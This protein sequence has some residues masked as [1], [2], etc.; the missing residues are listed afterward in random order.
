MRALCLLLVAHFAVFSVVTADPLQTCEADFWPDLVPEAGSSR[1][2]AVTTDLV[3]SKGSFHYESGKTYTGLC[4]STHVCM[5]VC[6][7][8][9]VYVCVFVALVCRDRVRYDS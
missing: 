1:D 8:T 5:C 4:A 2:F 6:V 7:S 3:F 9:H